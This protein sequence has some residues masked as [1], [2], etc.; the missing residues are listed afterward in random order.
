MAKDAGGTIPPQHSKAGSA[1]A[2]SRIAFEVG[3]LGRAC[4]GLRKN[5][6]A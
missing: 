6:T 1:E 2:N 5:N 4:E 3:G